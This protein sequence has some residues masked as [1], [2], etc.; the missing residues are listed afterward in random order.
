MFCV[1]DVNDNIALAQFFKYNS[2]MIIKWSGESL[3]WTAY[4]PAPPAVQFRCCSAGVTLF[5]NYNF[6]KSE[7]TPA[8]PWVT[9]SVTY[10]ISIFLSISVFNMIFAKCILFY[11]VF[12]PA[13]SLLFAL[14]GQKKKKKILTTTP[15]NLQLLFYSVTLFQYAASVFFFFFFVA[16]FLK[17]NL[18]SF[19]SSFFLVCCGLLLKEAVADKTKLGELVKPYIDNG[20]PGRARCCL[21]KLWLQI[22]GKRYIVSEFFLHRL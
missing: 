11:S 3:P 14:L 22:C 12:S 18:V 13:Q 15:K 19:C 17:F 4:Y 7:K 6:I 21:I 10:F 8:I 20:Y 9:I 16:S 2:C 1:F 5:S